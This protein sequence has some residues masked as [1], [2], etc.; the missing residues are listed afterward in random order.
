[1]GKRVAANRCDPFSQMRRH[2]NRQIL[3]TVGQNCHK[4]VCKQSGTIFANLC[5]SGII[6][7]GK[8]RDIHCRTVVFVPEDPA[9][10][11]MRNRAQR[12]RIGGDGVRRDPGMEEI[13]HH[14]QLLIRDRYLSALIPIL[15]RRRVVNIQ[16]EG[17]DA[18]NARKTRLSSPT[19]T[20]MR[21]F[22]ENGIVHVR[23]VP[24]TVRNPAAAVRSLRKHILTGNKPMQRA[25]YAAGQNLKRRVQHTFFSFGFRKSCQRGHCTYCVQSLCSNFP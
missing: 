21:Q 22:R 8:H 9:V 7:A 25:V 18:E 19:I 3:Q 5:E 2:R 17:A 1:M 15:L 4:R 11:K 12:Q 24:H 14:A 20:P 16:A 23:G 6:R 13:Q 10:G